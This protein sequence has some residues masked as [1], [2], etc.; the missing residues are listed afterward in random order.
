[1]RDVLRR[2]HPDAVVSI[3]S[4][5]LREYREYERA[6]TT[7]VD[8]AVKPTMASYVANITTR[9]HEL[10]PGDVPFYVMKSNGGVLSADE[11][12]HQPITTVLSGP[13]AGALGAALIAREAGFDR[14]LTCDGGGTSTDV[15][16]V[17]RRRADADHRGHR[18][19]LP[20]Q[21]PDDRR[22]HR[23]R[24]R[25]L[26]RLDLAGGHAEGRAAVGRRRP[27]AALLRPRRHRAD[28]HRRARGARPD[29]AAP[30]RRRDPAGRRGGPGRAAGARRPA[31]PEPGACA[32]GILEISAWNQ[33]NALRQVTVKR[34]LDVRDF[35]D[36]DL[37]RLRLAAGLPADRHPRAGRRAGAAATRATC[38]R[39]GC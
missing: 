23:R 34:G 11:V 27:R 17:A 36:G 8:A 37:R 1:M 29:P 32:T 38:R 2:E 18:R 15:S 4:E 30:A 6:V 16:V 25:R 5:V 3:S 19:P 20:Q 21:D 28:R 13:A 22:R 26:D 7:L 39:S 10:A 9:L 24:R 33:A 31:R 12:V 14:V 35:T